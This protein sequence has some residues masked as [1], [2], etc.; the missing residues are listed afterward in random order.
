[1][2]TGKC[3]STVSAAAISVPSSIVPEVASVIDAWIGIRFSRSAKTCWRRVDRRLQLQDVLHRLDDQDVRAAV[4]QV[5]ESDRGRD[6]RPRG[7]DGCRACGSS[8]AGKRPVGPIEPATKRGLSD[9]L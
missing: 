1:M 9:V 5:R 4:D 7:S 3:S 6:R 8:D 2:S